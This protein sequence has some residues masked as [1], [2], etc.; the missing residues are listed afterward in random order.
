ME[1]ILLTGSVFNIIGGTGILLSLFVKIPYGFPVI[2][3]VS[4]I[5]P[6]DYMLFRL[7]TAGTA[8]AFGAMYFYLYNNPG[9][10]VPFLYFGTF[11]KYW[12]FLASLVAVLRFGL[13]KSIFINFGCTNAGGD[14]GKQ[15]V[16]FIFQV[17]VR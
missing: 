8:F 13:P 3:Q 9:Y 4:E 2:P 1:W 6:K 11:L 12:A 17:T 15:H 7:F 5:N 14:G 10:A 16:L